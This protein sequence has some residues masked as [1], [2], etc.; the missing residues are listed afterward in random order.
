MIM[1]CFQKDSQVSSIT[2]KLKTMKG[3]KNQF[4]KNCALTIIAAL[5]S[6]TTEAQ[7]I[8]RKAAPVPIEPLGIKSEKL[9]LTYLFINN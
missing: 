4:K 8:I 3:L 7:A 2:M 9:T 1:H 5:V 6:A